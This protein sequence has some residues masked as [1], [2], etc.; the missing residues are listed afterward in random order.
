M[1]HRLSILL[2]V[3]FVLALSPLGACRSESVG[4]EILWDTWGVPHIFGDS[5]GEAFRAFGWAQM[6]A[7]GDLVLRLYGQARGRGAEYW[8]AEYLESDRWVRTMDIHGR[9]KAWYEEQSPAFRT[10]LDA[11]A[12]GINAYA[13]EHPGRIADDV[14]VVLPVD[15]VDVLAHTQRVI[16]FTFVAGVGVVDGAQHL[17]A[18]GSNTWAVGPSRTESGHALL[19]Q[20]PHLPWSGLFLFFE[21][22]IALSDVNVYGATL[23]GFPVLAIAFNDHLGWSHTVNRVDGADL[24]ELERVDGGYR[25]EGDSRPFEVDHHTILVREPGGSQREE[26]LAV[27]RSVHGPVVAESEERAVALRVVG[28][29]S[30]GMLEEW[31]DM[32][33]ATNLAEF[34]DALERLQIPTFTV[35]YADR[36]GH[37]LY[38]LGGRVPRRSRGDVTYWAGMV[39]GHSSDTLWD[40]VLAYDEL[41]RLLDPRSGWLQNANDPPWASTHPAELRAE[42]YPPYLPPEFMHFRAQQSARL[43]DEDAR[44]SFEEL[45]E[46]KHSTHMLMAERVMDDLLEAARAHGGPMARQAAEILERWDRRADADSRGAVLFHRWATAWTED[47]RLAEIP[48]LFRRQW[49]EEWP[50]STPDGIADPM[51][52]AR[53]LDAAARDLEKTY[54]ALDISW[55][56]VFRL[57]R[58]DRDLPANGGPGEPSGILRAA[59]FSP[60]SEHRFR[61]VAGDSYYA[62]IEFSDPVRARV[63]TAY[64]NATQPDSPHVGDQLELFARKDMRPAWRTRSEVEENLE[65][66]EVLPPGS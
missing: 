15:A 13:R 14:E 62:I 1:K 31:W 44:I 52:A 41:P 54:G 47:H 9:A 57:Q 11:F 48:L 46:Y 12:D 17:L 10:Q 7:H 64:G 8:G 33:R 60:S 59:S 61:M 28:L 34:E 51:G 22:H 3:A 21:A 65:R 19:L 25:W 39:P 45:V 37:I 5:P 50:L 23:I 29:G 63:L 16:H 42:D 18:R 40:D 4:T 36:A 2:S 26:S 35:M 55:G 24:F 6:H 27:R 20:N 58:G 43:L 32:G 66:R 56:E 49:D 38:F 30:P 53:I